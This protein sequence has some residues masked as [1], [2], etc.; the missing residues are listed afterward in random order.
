MFDVLEMI[1]RE[2]EERGFPISS[3][4]LVR[5]HLTPSLKPYKGKIKTLKT[6][7]D[8][9][10]KETSKCLKRSIAF[11]KGDAWFLDALVKIVDTKKAAGFK[12]SV[13]YELVR[14]AKNS[15]TGAIDGSAF[16]R[17]V[18]KV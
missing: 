12:T 13:S 8:S 1:Q 17:K 10:L 16:D 18:L 6:D 11:R 4:E 14:L 15:L 2:F 7:D 9:T 3:G 5:E